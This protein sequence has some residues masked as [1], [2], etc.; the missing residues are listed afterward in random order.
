[1]YLFV[2]LFENYPSKRTL[3]E[4]VLKLLFVL[5]SVYRVTF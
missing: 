3:T 1:M 4:G 5:M 2:L